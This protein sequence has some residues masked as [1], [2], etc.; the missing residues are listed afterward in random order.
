M[1]IDLRGGLPEDCGIEQDGFCKGGCGMQV[2]VAEPC[3]VL[4]YDELKEME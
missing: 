1:L 2:L 4:L 3:L